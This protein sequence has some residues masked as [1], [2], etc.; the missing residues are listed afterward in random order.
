MIKKLDNLWIG[1]DLL[2]NTEFKSA[3][4]SNKN[5]LIVTDNIVADLHLS[6]LTATLQASPAQILI[7]PVGEEHKSLATVEHILRHL[8]ALG[9]DRAATIISLGGGVIGDVVGLAAALYMRGINWVQVPTTLL[10]QVDAAIGGK[11][12]CNYLGIKNLIGTFYFPSQ[13][14]IDL[15]FIN[16]LP[17]REYTSGLAEVV[18]YG[19][20]CDA[21]FFQWLELHKEQILQRDIA[22]VQSMI[23]RS[24]ELKLGI[25]AIDPLDLDTRRILNFGHTFAHAIEG[26]T[27]YQ[28]YSHGE[29]VALG[30]LL[31]THWAVKLGLINKEILARLGQLLMYFGLPTR[32]D[33]HSCDIKMLCSYMAHDKKKHAGIFRFIL[34]VALGKVTSIEMTTL[35]NLEEILQEYA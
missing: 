2:K 33:S 22:I 27:R 16:T 35:D 9:Y 10:A 19:M 28:Y 32:I 13:I 25:V 14:W 1:V 5:F 29:A 26:L 21:N 23:Q 8:H 6:W 31:A 15:Q 24:C 18:K 7:L 17:I 20:A 4:A 3:I 11:T 30:M 12:G 34:P